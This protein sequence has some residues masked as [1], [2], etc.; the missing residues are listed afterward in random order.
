MTSVTLSK[1]FPVNECMAVRQYHHP[2]S[3]LVKIV[4]KKFKKIYFFI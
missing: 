4:I 2:Q 1:M 3:G